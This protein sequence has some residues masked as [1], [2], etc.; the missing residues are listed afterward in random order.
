[1]RCVSEMKG[2]KGRSSLGSDLTGCYSTL[3]ESAEGRRIKGITQGIT[4][5]TSAYLDLLFGMANRRHDPKHPKLS[6]VVNEVLD[7]WQA[8]EKVLIFCFR[9]NTA[10]RL[11]DIF[12]DR[13]RDELKSRKK[14]CLGGEVQLKTLRARLTGRDRDLIVLGLDC[15][16]GPWLGRAAR[17]FHLPPANSFWRMPNSRN[18]PVS[19]S[20]LGLR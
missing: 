1:M 13:I 9:V 18:S 5:G 7:L 2:G 12:S 17:I 15:L 10:E 4:G 3:H 6:C 11:R 19:R 14:K 20:S 8:G 16:L